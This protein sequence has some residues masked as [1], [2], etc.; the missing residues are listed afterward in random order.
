[1]QNDPIPK[2]TPHRPKTYYAPYNRVTTTRGT[3]RKNRKL[4]TSELNDDSMIESRVL[5]AGKTRSDVGLLIEKKQRMPLAKLKG[6]SV[7]AKPKI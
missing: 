5:T 4:F 2:R 1:M 6:F 3:T 7:I